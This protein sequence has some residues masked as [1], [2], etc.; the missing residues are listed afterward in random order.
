MTVNKSSQQIA[1]GFT[2]MA[3]IFLV[4]LLLRKKKGAIYTIEKYRAKVDTGAYF[5]MKDDAYEYGWKPDFSK[6]AK[7]FK[8]GEMIGDAVGDFPTTNYKGQQFTFVVF[9]VTILYG[10]IVYLCIDKNNLSIVQ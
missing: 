9:E 10:A 1:I 3:I 5:A 7:T 4:V 2:L 8:A 6:P